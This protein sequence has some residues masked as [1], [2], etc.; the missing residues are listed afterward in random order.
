MPSLFWPASRVFTD[1][2]GDPLL[3]GTF[4]FPCLLIGF[5]LL[6]Q[7]VVVEKFA[8]GLFNLSFVLLRMLWH[9]DHLLKVPFQAGGSH[10]A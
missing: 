1:L 10:K 4:H 9:L 5:S 2:S 7:V 8:S 6:A 3:A